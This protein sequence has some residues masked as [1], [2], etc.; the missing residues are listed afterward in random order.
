[1][2]FNLLKLIFGNFTNDDLDINNKNSE[3]IEIILLTLHS[4][5]LYINTG[6]RLNKNK[7]F[8]AEFNTKPTGLI[9][10]S[11]IIDKILLM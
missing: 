6:M 5:I 7:N 2:K 4:R 11:S 9:I 8:I 1:M 10:K 3:L